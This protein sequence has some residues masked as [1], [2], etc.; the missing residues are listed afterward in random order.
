[1]LPIILFKIL[2]SSSLHSKNLKIKI[3]GTVILR[4]GFYGCEVRSLVLREEQSLK[5]FEN[6]M[7]KKYSHLSWTKRQETGEDCI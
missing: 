4:A 1:M 5:A 7:L 3:H 6:R 2:F